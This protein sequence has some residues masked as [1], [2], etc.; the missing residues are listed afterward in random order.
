MLPYSQEVATAGSMLDLADLYAGWPSLLSPKEIGVYS[1]D[2]T[3]N[4]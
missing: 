1:P 2:Q 3:K 4:L